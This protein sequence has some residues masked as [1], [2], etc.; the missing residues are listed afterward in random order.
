MCGEVQRSSA[1]IAGDI[2][3]GT[4]APEFYGKF[5]AGD[6]EEASP[7]VYVVDVVPEAPVWN[8]SI[9]R[10]QCPGCDGFFEGYLEH[11]ETAVNGDLLFLFDNGLLRMIESSECGIDNGGGNNG[12]GGI[13][14]TKPPQEFIDVPYY[15]REFQNPDEVVSA[16]GELNTTLE[17]T[18]HRHDVGQVSGT[19]TDSVLEFNTRLYNGKF[20]GPTLRFK[21]GDTVNVKLKN[22]LAD[23]LVPYSGTEWNEFDK[24]QMTNLHT[25][26]LHVSPSGN[27]DNVWIEVE[28]GE[29]FDYSYNP[30]AE[31]APGMSYYHSHLHGAGFVQVTGGLYG[32]MIVDLPDDALYAPLKNLPESIIMLGIINGNGIED[33]E[34]YERVNLVSGSPFPAA[35]TGGLEGFQRYALVNGVFQPTMTFG[36]N[37]LQHFRITNTGSQGFLLQTDGDCS[38][39]EIAKDAIYLDEPIPV[40]L[41][42][43]GPANRADLLILC[44]TPGLFSMY[45]NTTYEVEEVKGD[46]V[47]QDIFYM[48]VNAAAAGATTINDIRLPALP[49]YLPELRH[50]MDRRIYKAQDISMDYGEKISGNKLECRGCLSE[51]WKVGRAYEANITSTAFH[52]LH[53]HVNHYQIIDWEY[54]GGS[55]PD[56]VFF[57]EGERRDTIPLISGLRVTVRFYLDSYTGLALSHC[58]LAHHADKGMMR[59][60]YIADDDDL[61]ARDHYKIRSIHLDDPHPIDKRLVSIWISDDCTSA[62]TDCTEDNEFLT[63]TGVDTNGEE[64]YTMPLIPQPV[65]GSYVYWTYDRGMARHESGTFIEFR[66]TGQYSIVGGWSAPFS[67]DPLEPNTNYHSALNAQV[68]SDADWKEYEFFFRDMVPDEAP[69]F[70]PQNLFASSLGFINIQIPASIEIKR[71][72]FIREVPLE[73]DVLY[74]VGEVL[75]N[76]PTRR[77]TT[78]GETGSPI[79]SFIPPTK[80]TT[81][82]EA[83]DDSAVIA[84]SVAS[85]AAVLAAAA[86]VYRRMTRTTEQGI[87]AAKFYG[88]DAGESISA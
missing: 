53:M 87:F 1:I 61:D 35:I 65:T 29:E 19:N 8:H 14:P 55:H 86:F 59:L 69:G 46:V 63:K 67:A 48:Q 28:P 44:R 18:S 57:R 16:N 82:Q 78:P 76:F 3:R 24:A 31:H 20:P 2:Y 30:H 45:S 74:E 4:K 15:Y 84:G 62:R 41:V 88:S 26:G 43:L 73:D 83:S 60:Q 47:K 85:V 21:A 13:I 68:N 51:V 71:I 58:H 33:S 64:Y 37:Q 17:V 10:Y 49:D 11:I 39:W 56:L 42:Y 77:P 70:D 32:A 40:G 7:W 34:S 72:G 36:T 12:G 79:G 50:S 52:P 6:W 22:S 80:G 25:H 5:F 23:P 75:P 38:I 81:F 66:G 27:A 9:H 54:D